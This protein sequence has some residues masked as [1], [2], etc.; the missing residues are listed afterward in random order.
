MDIEL[1]GITK[2]FGSFTAVNGVDLKVHRGEVLGLLGE[3]G[4]GKSTLMNVLCGLYAPSEGQIFVNGKPV[5]F[6]GP[7]EA[8]AAGIGMVHQHFMLIPVFT[9]AENVVLG[10]EPTGRF[11]HLDLAKARA[12]VREINDAYGLEVDPDALI[13]S[14][15]VGVQQR[16]EIIKVLFRSADLVIFDE[17][18]AVLTPQEVVDFFQIVKGLRD[19]GKAIIFITHKLGEIREIADRIAVLRRGEIVGNADHPNELSEAE[20][21]EMMVGRPVSFDVDKKPF[22]PGATLLEVKGLTVLRENDDVAVDDLSMVVRSGEIVGIAGVQGNGQSALVEALTGL[23]RVAGGTVSFRGKDITRASARER[24]KLGFA[25]I[26]EDRQRTGLIPAFTI[27][28]NMVLDSYYDDR[29][30]RGPTM[31]WSVINEAA[32]RGVQDFDVRTESIFDAVS[33][34]SGGNQ[35]KVIVARELS[36][37]TELLIAAQPTRGLDVGSIEYIHSRIVHARDEGDGVL[38]VSSELDEILALSDRILVMFKGR[39]VAEFDAATADKTTIGLA[40]AG[41]YEGAAA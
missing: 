21:A 9:V 19:A 7:G 15:P 40:M 11:D 30:S 2:R 17:P 10:V 28:E 29:F 16:V 24:H 1:R 8:I 25:H 18:T 12:Q 37:D 14:L 22:Q 23:T 33:T 13:D 6:A 26:P 3:N 27:A 31:L 35:Q 4:A 36:R 38:I 39:I 34:L 20:L 32:A 41:R 5:E